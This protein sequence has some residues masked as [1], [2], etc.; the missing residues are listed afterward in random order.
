MR[1]G[2]AATL[3]GASLLPLAGIAIPGA[4]P[5]ANECTAATGEQ[6]RDCDCDPCQ[7]P[8]IRNAVPSPRGSA[9]MYMDVNYCICM[10]ACHGGSGCTRL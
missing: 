3:P 10:Q 6:D 9:F 5:P 7:H 1:F 8:V 2:D 4:D